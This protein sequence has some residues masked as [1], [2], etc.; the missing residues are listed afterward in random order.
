MQKLTNSKS[1]LKLAQTAE[2]HRN[3]LRSLEAA[4]EQDP[5]A[6]RRTR[7]D[8]ELHEA[9]RLAREAEALAGLK[10]GWS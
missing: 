2:S 7:S 10:G 5:L 9:A 8:H 4:V 1:Q 3:R 6:Y